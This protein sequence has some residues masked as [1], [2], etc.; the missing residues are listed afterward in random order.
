MSSDDNE[1]GYGHPPKKHRFTKGKSGN[2][3]GRPKGSRNARSIIAAV[4]NEKVIIRENGKKKVIT[5]QEAMIKHMVNQAASGSA[6][7]FRQLLPLMMDDQ[8]QSHGAGEVK[9]MDEKK[10]AELTANILKRV[11]TLTAEDENDN[12]NG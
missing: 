9:L 6:A 8:K 3:S 1:I 4:F 7:A 12:Q 5:K 11:S 10:S 2:P